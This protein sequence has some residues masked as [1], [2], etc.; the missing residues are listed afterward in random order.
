MRGNSDLAVVNGGC[1]QGN[2]EIY[3]ATRPRGCCVSWN[4]SQSLPPAPPCYLQP[5]SMVPVDLCGRCGGI[6]AVSNGFGKGCLG[7]DRFD[8]G[9]SGQYDYVGP[10]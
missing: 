8:I 2:G 3:Y 7:R 10:Y 5:T 1:C 6:A 9:G 4:K